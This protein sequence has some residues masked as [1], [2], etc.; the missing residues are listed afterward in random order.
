MRKYGNILEKYYCKRFAQSAG[1]GS[2]KGPLL[3]RIFAW[4]RKGSTFGAHFRT[5]GDLL[6]HFWL[7]FRA[8]GAL[9]ERWGPIF[10]SQRL[11]PPKVL[12]EE[13]PPKYTHSLGPILKSF[14]ECFFDFWGSVFKRRSLLSSGTDFSWIVASFRHY[15]LVFFY[16]CR[17]F[18]F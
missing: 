15:F 14:L 5:R 6:C 8:L 17:H 1:P 3:E 10:W 11:E 16:T 7:I 4:L 18:C 12:Q 9:W 2:E 13:F